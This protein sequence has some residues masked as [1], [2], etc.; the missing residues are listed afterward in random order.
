[1]SMVTASD[2]MILSVTLFAIGLAGFVLRRNIIVMFM[3]A[4]L[5]LNAV[6]LNF[7]GF[8]AEWANSTGETFA[9]FVIAVAAAEA[10]IGLAL[11]M[12]LFRARSTVSSGDW[13]K[14]KG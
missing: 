5:M 12:L 14:L 4:E 7:V 13:R 1:M 11:L 2:Y 10:A 9:V 6:N 3:S 8:S